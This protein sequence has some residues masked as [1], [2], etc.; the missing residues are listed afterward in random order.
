MRKSEAYETTETGRNANAIVSHVEIL[1]ERKTN[2]MNTLL[3]KTVLVAA[4]ALGFAVSGYTHAASTAV[5]D[6]IYF[7][8][9]IVTLNVS[10]D[11]RCPVAGS[12]ERHQMIQR[13]S[14]SAFFIPRTGRQFAN[15]CFVNSYG[16]RW[17][18]SKERDITECRQTDRTRASK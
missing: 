14:V 15:Y 5:P 2:S 12:G 10:R 16:N 11:R 3:A 6:A 13:R 1:Q 9:K 4:T 17:Q 7:N 8:G 18:F